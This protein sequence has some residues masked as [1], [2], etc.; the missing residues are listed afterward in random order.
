MDT[1]QNYYSNLHTMLLSMNESILAIFNDKEEG[2][3]IT[4]FLCVDVLVQLIQNG[5]QCLS[6]DFIKVLA[7]IPTN[8]FRHTL[9]ASFSFMEIIAGCISDTQK[10]EQSLQALLRDWY[11]Y[12][13]TEFVTNEYNEINDLLNR[14]SN[15][16]FCTS[17]FLVGQRRRARGFLLFLSSIHSSHL[18]VIFIQFPGSLLYN[19]VWHSRSRLLAIHS[20]RFVKWSDG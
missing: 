16:V 5:S 17:A 13:T 1:L 4:L 2:M 15:S 3:L 6:A 20:V 12:T 18:F 14:L 9:E 19:W 11:A 8:H 10:K 7:N